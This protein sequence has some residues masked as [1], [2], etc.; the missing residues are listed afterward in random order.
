[1]GH[2]TATSRGSLRRRPVDHIVRAVTRYALALCTLI[3]PALLTIP[4]VHHRALGPL[5]SF[6]YVLAVAT[7]AWATGFWGGILVAAAATP[8]LVGIATGGKAFYIPQ[9]DYA[10]LAVMILISLLASR[11]AAY[12]RRVEQV[13]RSANEQLEVRVRQR[14]AELARATES[15]RI[16]LTSIGD[17]VIATDNEG[18]I[19]MM[20]PIAQQL[21]DWSE[22]QAI[23]RR[24]DEVFVIV[25]ED[26]RATVENPVEKV[27]KLGTIVGL[28]NH[29]ILITRQGREVPIDDSGA[30]IRTAEGEVAGVVLVFRDITERRRAERERQRLRE[31]DERLVDILAKVNDGFI[32][33]NPDWTISYVNLKAASMLRQSAEEIQGKAFWVV[34]PISRASAAG[35]DLERAM[36]D[37]MAVRFDA[38]HAPFNTWY[39]VSA[40]PNPNDGGLALFIRDITDQRRLEDQLRQAQKMEAIGRLAGGLAHDFNNLLTVIIG[41]SATVNSRLQPEDPLRKAVTEIIQAGQSAASLTAQL[42]TFS[43]KQVIQ[44]QLLDLNVFIDGT[45]DMLQR[46]VGEDNEIG[47]VLDD[48]PCWINID[49][50]QLTQ[51][52]M[53][54][55]VNARDAMPDG[56][57]LSIETRIEIRN[58]AALDRQ[59]LRPAGRFAKLTVT[60]NGKGIDAETQAH[61]F[62]PFFTTKETGKGTGLGLATVYGI[63]SQL[64]GWIDVYSELGHGASFRVFFPLADSA[65]V[66]ADLV[67]ADTAS[68]RSATILVVEDQAAIRMFAED[69]LADAGH[70]V[71]SASNGREALQVAARH[72]GP[73]DLL[74]T[75]VV[76]PEMSGPDLVRQLATSRPHL[77]VLYA[78]GYTDH[79]LLQRESIAQGTAFLQKPFWPA[80]LTAKVNQLLLEDT[81]ARRAEQA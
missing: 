9:I 39:E 26:S 46:L 49:S 33:L 31:A 56:G 48:G 72:P 79:I 5:V 8:V 17:A 20:N 61:I 44:P 57:K 2:E 24:L 70:T 74:I 64:G 23:G 55:V 10:A 50:A 12:R 54:L 45:R 30:P 38:H 18:R 4:L 75:D 71:L 15:L 43:R 21:T 11:V 63:V 7:A 42:L 13:L 62:E 77:V 1:M 25:N 27:L 66:E 29:T 53:N 80:S 69:V 47:V 58:E 32:T 68:V 3:V 16:T 14:T 52:L 76:M 78:S 51:I 60:D 59:I 37:G 6:A 81:K 40:H 73:I 19:T 41:Y 35:E 28:A 22:S 65:G 67:N 34:A 36:K